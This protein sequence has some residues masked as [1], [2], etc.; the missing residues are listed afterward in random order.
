[1]NIGTGE[2]PDGFPDPFPLP[3]GAAAVGSASQGGS[4]VVWFSSSDRVDDLTA[5][6]DDEL[7]SS[8]WTIDAQIDYS[9]QG[10]TYKAYT[11]SGNGY[12]GQVL[13]GEGAPGAVGFE[14]EFA[15]WVSLTPS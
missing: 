13:V 2:L 6:F 8:G 4:F 9:Q 15:F 1:M 14:G 11:V 7:A 5:Y 3:D 10:V 12:E